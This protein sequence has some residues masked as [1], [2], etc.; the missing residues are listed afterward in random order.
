[1]RVVNGNRQ[2]TLFATEVDGPF[3]G[4]VL[5][6]PVDTVLT[7]RVP[8]RLRGRLQA[9]QRVR[10]PLGRGNSPAVG[11][12]VQVVDRAE[13]ELARVKDVLEILDDP[14]LIDAAMLDLTR[15]MASYYACS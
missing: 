10:V 15:W 8:S 13:V 3:A 1:M 5:N 12:C 9:G 4:V 2:A 7:Y 11:Y 6:R 14:P